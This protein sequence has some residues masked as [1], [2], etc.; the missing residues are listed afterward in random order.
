MKTGIGKP[1]SGIATFGPEVHENPYP[2]YEKLR[3]DSPV[4]WD[5]KLGGW[6]VTRYEDAARVVNDR[7]YSSSRV[8]LARD[9]FRDARWKPLFDVL[10]AKMSEQDDP[11][12]KRVRGLINS[13]FA[14][15]AVEQWAPILEAR[16]GGLL[17]NAIKAN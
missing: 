13:A 8:A 16:A 11:D 5:E 6:L 15:T 2:W 7:H 12:H 9:R 1:V 14:R 10:K 4:D 3:R 17:E